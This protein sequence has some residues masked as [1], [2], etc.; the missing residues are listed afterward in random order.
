M[1]VSVKKNPERRTHSEPAQLDRRR[2]D[3]DIGNH[4]FRGYRPDRLVRSTSDDRVSKKPK[5]PRKP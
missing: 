5:T 1:N 3:E 2:S 4:V